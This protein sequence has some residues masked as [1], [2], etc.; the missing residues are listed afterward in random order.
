MRKIVAFLAV[1]GIVVFSSCTGPEG[2]PGLDGQDG[3]SAQAFEIKNKSLNRIADND[4]E[5][6]ST[7]E[8][9]LGGIYL[10]MKMC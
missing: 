9:Y 10:M 2:S 7:F 5:F 3:L 4:Y 1:I 6:S 8:T